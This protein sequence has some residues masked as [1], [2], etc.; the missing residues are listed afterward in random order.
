MWTRLPRFLQDAWILLDNN[1]T[2]RAPLLAF[3]HAFFSSYTHE[4]H[5]SGLGLLTPHD[6]RHGLAEARLAGRAAVLAAAHATHPERFPRGVPRPAPL[7]TEVWINRPTSR[8]QSVEAS[9]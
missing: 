5:H 6:V 4:H 8:P 3:C 9:Q 2:E 1:G 7:P